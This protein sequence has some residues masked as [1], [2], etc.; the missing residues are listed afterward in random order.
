[1]PNTTAETLTPRPLAAADHAA[2]LAQLPD[3]VPVAWSVAGAATRD[4][5]LDLLRGLA[6]AILIVNHLH[7]ASPIDGV[8]GAVLSAA[9]VLVAV[10]GV[11]AGMVFGRRWLTLGPQ[12]ATR[13]LLR[14]ALK[15]YVAAVTVSAVVWVATLVP[16]LATDALTISRFG[17]TSLD[18]Y[19]H[20][21]LLRLALAVVTLEA[22][23]WQLGILGLFVAL[24]ALAP[25]VLWALSRGR[26]VH[27][28]AVS[29][30]A[31][32]AWRASPVAVLP[33]HSELPFPLLVWQVLFV[34]G[35]VGGW[36]REPIARWVRAWRG[37]VVGAVVVVA[38]GAVALQLAGPHV[39]GADGWAQWRG[40][41]FDKRSL[42]PARLV[43][44]MSIAAALYLA[45]RRCAEPVR[46]TLGRVLLPLGRNSFYVFIVHAFVC[47][48][49][50]TG[51][52]AV[53]VRP[54]QL[55]A[56]ALQVG[57]I[58]A[59]VALVRRRVLF[60]VIPR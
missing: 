1:M 44:M 52:A 51:L 57:A 55:G 19:A 50:A 27:V 25:A 43:A 6:M 37:P 53:G 3:H 14:R 17:G 9:E 8:T 59:L 5:A 32:L 28:L 47:L 45:L 34:N 38:L 10:S 36:H 54:G 20:D 15:I 29:W 23:P 21:G 42:D 40:D 30:L 12:A 39:L 18:L 41:H 4:V 7:L 24:L 56:A 49:I 13:L 48:A 26:W 22:G 58:A 60:A 33:S 11:V 16:G 46:R 35:M 31:F 2:P